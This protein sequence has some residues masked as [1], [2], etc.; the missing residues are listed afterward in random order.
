VVAITGKSGSIT[1]F[2]I[3]T[4]MAFNIKPFFDLNKM[5]TSVFERDMGDDPVFA[6]TPKNGVIILNEN[7]VKDSSKKELDNTI[8]HEQVHVDQ[9]KDE[10]KNPGTGLD[11][12]VGAGK[13]MFKGKE[14]D[15]S[16]MQ[17]GKGPWEKPAYAAEKK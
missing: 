5:S 17:A 7:A 15:Y 14:Y 10:I 12:N 2:L 4:R 8:A 3:E 1:N 13:V 9:F 11:Y 16:V 6:R